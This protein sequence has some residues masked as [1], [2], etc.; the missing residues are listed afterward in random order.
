MATL[1]L[2]PYPVAALGLSKSKSVVASAV[3]TM[4]QLSSSKAASVTEHSK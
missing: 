4:L 2:M 3:R 1:A